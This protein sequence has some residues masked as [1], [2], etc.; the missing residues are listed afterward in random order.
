M[1]DGSNTDN[2]NEKTVGIGELGVRGSSEFWKAYPDVKSR[3]WDL[4][5]LRH[6]VTPQ[7]AASIYGVSDVNQSNSTTW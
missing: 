2:I 3:L 1:V 7:A 6:I 4:T 5:G